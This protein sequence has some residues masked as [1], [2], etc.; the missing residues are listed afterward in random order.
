M[1]I[2]IS[3]S[4]LSQ[5]ERLFPTQAGHSQAS[6]LISKTDMRGLLPGIPKGGPGGHASGAKWTLPVSFQR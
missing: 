4:S 5:A 1:R 6:R 3:G 2:S